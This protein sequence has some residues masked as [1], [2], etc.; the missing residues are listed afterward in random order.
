MI[1]AFF[2]SPCAFKAA[3]GG[4]HAA[5]WN[6]GENGARLENAEASAGEPAAEKI[7]FGPEPSREPMRRA[8]PKAESPEPTLLYS[9]TAARPR[10][11]G[12]QS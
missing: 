2:L 11:N 5:G 9:L 12:P 1:S 4:A 6:P 3:F 7:S 10:T 8:K